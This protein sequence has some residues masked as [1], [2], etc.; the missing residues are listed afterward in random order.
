M[1]GRNRVGLGER[2]KERAKRILSTLRGTVLCKIGGV[3]RGKAPV[4]MLKK[5]KES[6]E[7]GMKGL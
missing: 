1:A 4:S 2:V 5:D 6:G 7:T 3:V